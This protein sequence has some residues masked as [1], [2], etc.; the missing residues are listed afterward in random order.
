MKL[1]IF[2]LDDTLIDFAS[3]REKAYRRLAGHLEERGVDSAAFLRGC[4]D[5]E[6][7][8]FALFEQGR[9]SREAYRQ[10]RFAEPLQRMGVT[11]EEALVAQL[12]RLFMDCVNDAPQL[13]PDVLPVLEALRVRGVRT[14]ILTNGPADG[15][16]RKLEASGLGHRVDHVAIGEETGFSKPLAAAFHGVVERFSLLPGEALMVGDSPEL[17]YDA[18][19]RAGLAGLLLDREG[20][21][22]DRGSATIRGLDE[23]LSCLPAPGP[24]RPRPA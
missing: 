21:H 20:R 18:A 14:A 7:P 22:R 23:L 3:T 16:R 6:R 1:V 2:D 11:P 24:V 17:D 9:L 4:A 8:L 12:N 10:R 13:Y 5:C 19:L 15:Q